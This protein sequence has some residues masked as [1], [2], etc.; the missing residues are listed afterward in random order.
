MAKMKPEKLLTLFEELAEKMDINIVQGKGD[1]QGGMCS[2]NDESYIVLNKLKP[3]DQRLG[4]L[5]KEFSKM[6]LKKIFIQPALREYILDT[7]QELL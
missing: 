2:L 7:Q 4:V 6:N 3:V 5:V 1:F